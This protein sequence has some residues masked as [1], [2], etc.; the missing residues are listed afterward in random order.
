MLTQQGLLKTDKV[1]IM[2]LQFYAPIFLLLSICDRDSKREEE[3][4]KTLVEH[5]R[6]F[7]KIYGGKK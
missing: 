3:A 2:T 6:Q 5:I 7:N 1:D 4:L